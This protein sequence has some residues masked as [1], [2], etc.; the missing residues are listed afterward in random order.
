MGRVIGQ[1][2]VAFDRKTVRITDFI[3]LNTADGTFRPIC[4]AFS[5]DGNPLYISST[6][7]NELRSVAPS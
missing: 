2:V 3:S 5:H 4:V 1:K 7:L 6:G